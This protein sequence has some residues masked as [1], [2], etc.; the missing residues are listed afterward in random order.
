MQEQFTRFFSQISSTGSEANS[1]LLY[2]LL[3]SVLIFL[4]M[5]I[6]KK[7]IVKIFES[8]ITDHKVRY[9]WNK[10][11][12]YIT[13]IVTFILIG[14]LWL[15]GVQSLATFLGLLSAGIAIALKDVLTNLAGWI[16]IISRRPFDV[17][18]RIEID[19]CKGDVIDQRI[20]EFSILEIGNWVAADQSTGRIIHIPNG[21]VFNKDLANYDK[22]FKYVWNEIPILVTFESDW[23]KAKELLQKIANDNSDITSGRVERQI[24]RAARKFLIYYRHLTPIVYTDIK[25]SGVLLT[26]RYLCETRTRRGTQQEIQEAILQEFAQHTNIEFAYPTTRLY[27]ENV[28]KYQ[29]D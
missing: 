19:G 22:G 12:N 4:V 25:D 16:F 28:Q 13:Y 17:G 29:Q 2:R 10:V 15:E 14:R 6:A 3:I 24:K 5:W 27:R 21:K 26:I 18:D 1:I 20:F 9:R 8:K 11:I 23:K 7:L